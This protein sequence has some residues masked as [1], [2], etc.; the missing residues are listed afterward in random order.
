M[1]IKIELSALENLLIQQKKIVIEKL[2]YQT[3]YY[4]SENTPGHSKSM[5]I[6]K[7]LFTSFG[8]ESKLPDDI[9]VLKKYIK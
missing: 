5:S 7:D 6:D 2:L 8:M 9:Q 4:N 1:E 3:S